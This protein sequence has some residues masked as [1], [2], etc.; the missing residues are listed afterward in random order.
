MV[1]DLECFNKTHEESRSGE[2]GE[3]KAIFHQD[4]SSNGGGGSNIILLG[5]EDF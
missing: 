3:G 1:P 4:E 5:A 2:W